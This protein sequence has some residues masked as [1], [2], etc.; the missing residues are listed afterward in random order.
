MKILN[1]LNKGFEWLMLIWMCL[2]IPFA[3]LSM[4]IVDLKEKLCGEKG[5]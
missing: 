3:V 1:F 4:A 5:W 2:L